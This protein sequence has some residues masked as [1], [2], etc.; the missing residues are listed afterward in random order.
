ML[1]LAP[2][3]MPVIPA[4]YP[5]PIAA[6]LAEDPWNGPAV[7]VAPGSIVARGRQCTIRTWQQPA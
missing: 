6:S 2:G 7:S 5:V 1:S 4:Q 3:E